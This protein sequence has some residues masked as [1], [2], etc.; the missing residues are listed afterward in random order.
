MN[1][2]INAM[3]KKLEK[4][5]NELEGS[6][7]PMK[8]DKSKGRIDTGLSTFRANK[9]DSKDTNRSETEGRTNRDETKR[10]EVIH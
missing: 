7:R 3:T 4:N 2:K 9:L 10:D 8:K 5:I 6:V 1:E